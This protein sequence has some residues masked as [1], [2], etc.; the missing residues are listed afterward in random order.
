MERK[1]LFDDGD[2]RDE[3]YLLAGEEVAF[4]HRNRSEIRIAVEYG[5]ERVLHFIPINGEVKRV[6]VVQ[7]LQSFI[8]GTRVGYRWRKRVCV[9]EEPEEIEAF[10]K[11]L[12]DNPDWK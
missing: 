2:I 4:I 10:W 3:V 11:E 9:V 12:V 6:E 8:K 7:G 1:V 5:R